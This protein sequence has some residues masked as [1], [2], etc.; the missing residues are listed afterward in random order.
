MTLC[1]IAFTMRFECDAEKRRTNFQ[2]HDIDFADVWKIFDN[3][4]IMLTDNRFN[5]GEIRFMTLYQNNT[6][7][8][9]SNGNAETRTE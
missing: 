1:K 3:P 9:L 5:Y 4:F 2:K 7:F 8:Y 6:G